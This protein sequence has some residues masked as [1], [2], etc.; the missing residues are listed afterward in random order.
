MG[1]WGATEGVCGAER[2]IETMRTSNP[3]TRFESSPQC[4]IDVRVKL[5]SHSLSPLFPFPPPICSPPR[6]LYR[7]AHFSRQPSTL[8]LVLAHPL[9]TRGRLRRPCRCGG[10]AA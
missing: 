9:T 5:P 6:T 1:R 4:V 2:A 8:S 10:R 7:R 3:P